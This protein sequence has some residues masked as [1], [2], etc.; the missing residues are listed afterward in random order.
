VAERAVASV[1]GHAQGVR[2]AL[3]RLYQVSAALAALCL[4]AIAGL[5]V[6]QVTGRSLGVLVPG[7]DDLAGYALMAS[8]FLGLA[9]TLRAGAHI[10]V[11]LLLSHAPPAR[12][13]RLELWCLAV[14]AAVCA[15]VC[16]YVVEMAK[17]AWR[18]G[19]KSTGNLPVPLWIPE[20]VMALGIAILTIAFIDDF[21][22]V[23]SGEAPSYPDDAAAV[24]DTAVV[25]DGQG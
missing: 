16:W 4:A 13:R 6:I 2:G 14:G 23:L 3:D 17:D 22:R 24:E 1:N 25:A 20:S 5:V 18:F 19:E 8:T 15:Y 9:P 11:T 12:K 7:A 10:R 21:V